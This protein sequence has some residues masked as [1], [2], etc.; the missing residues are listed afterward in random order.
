M[1]DFIDRQKLLKKYCPNCG[2]KMDKNK[3]KE[4]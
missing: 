3:I 4:K 1:F 2:Y